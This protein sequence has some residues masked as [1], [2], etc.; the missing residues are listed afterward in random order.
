MASDLLVHE[1]LRLGRV[2]GL[3]VAPS[4]VAHQVDHH[5]L[6]EAHSVVH[7]QLRGEHARLGIVAVD[8]QDGRLHQLGD[9]RAVLGGAGV[10]HAL[11][12]EADLVVDDDVNRAAN[13]EAP[14]L[15][16]LQRFHDHAL[17]GE[18]RIAM[19]DERH[20]LV[21]V[22]VSAPVLAGAHGTGDHRRDD[23]QVR[24]IE[25]QRQVHFAARRHDVGRETLVVLHVAVAVGLRHHAF[26]LVEEILRILAENVHQHVQP[27]TVRHADHRFHAAPLA[28]P[29]QGFVQ[30]ADQGLGA[31]E[32]EPLGAR[33]AGVQ[34]PFEA[35]GGTQAVKD[36]E[37]RLGRERRLAACGFEALAHPKLLR[38]IG[39]V[40]V[41]DAEGAAV[42]AFQRRHDVAQRR[43]RRVLLE[44]LR[45]AGV[46][47]GVQVGLAEAVVAELQ[48]RRRRA[49]PQAEGIEA[50]LAMA[51]VAVGADEFQHADLR[52]FVR[53]RDIRRDPLRARLQAVAA[54]ALEVA[55]HR[56]VGNVL[57]AAVHARQRVEMA[58]PLG[59]HAGGVF[60]V[61]L[62]ERLD[63][64]GAGGQVRT[65]PQACQMRGVHRS[66]IAP[67][68]PLSQ[69][70]SI[71]A[72]L[73]HRRIHAAGLKR[74]G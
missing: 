42:D 61:R 70:A 33:K 40:H 13:A 56:A 6:L 2:L 31:F 60:E 43:A 38:I 28:K 27:P 66:R 22:V 32:A 4:P 3:V 52:P 68:D 30:H 17:A 72:Q 34:M 10:L 59:G 36:G 11:G 48:L 39:D 65:R 15:R 19:H 26:E 74:R 9:L 53:R 47:H 73:R 20:H 25:R 49:L 46:E 29:L 51:A 1:R 54:Q 45:G 58:A 63:V 21:A 44:E 57:H 50:R 16:H 64:H 37:S 41:L 14:C 67:D 55:H 23:L 24:G 5:V 18:R 69:R 35:L 71:V 62:E 12:R 8:V 7:R